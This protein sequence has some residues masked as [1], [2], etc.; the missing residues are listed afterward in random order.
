MPTTR[1]LTVAVPATTFENG[2]SDSAS[3]RTSFAS[4]PVYDGSYSTDEQVRHAF[5]APEELRDGVLYDG[6][7][8]FNSVNRYYQDAPDLSTVELGGGGLPGSPYAPN[9]VSPGEGHGDD[10][11]AIPATG[12]AATEA[13]RGAGGAWAGNGLTSPNTTARQLFPRRIGDSLTLGRAT[14]I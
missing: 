4:S 12:V 13:N 7:Y 11:S 5:E 2:R 6:G 9:I 10:A 3:L 8:A 14:R 1:Q